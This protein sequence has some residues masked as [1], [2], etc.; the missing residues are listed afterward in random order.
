MDSPWC[1][2]CAKAIIDSG[3]AALVALELSASQ[4]CTNCGK[5]WTVA[6]QPES[7]G[8]NDAG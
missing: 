2:G 7:K 6:A 5:L 1:P 4:S 8:G 3:F